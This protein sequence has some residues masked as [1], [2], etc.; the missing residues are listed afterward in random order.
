MGLPISF[1]PTFGPWGFLCNLINLL[2]SPNLSLEVCAAVT[3]E[4]SDWTVT[5]TPDRVLGRGIQ[6]SNST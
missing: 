3:P 1:H 4:G 5:H 2:D 6:L